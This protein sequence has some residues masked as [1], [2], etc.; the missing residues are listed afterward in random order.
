MSML[1]SDV[2]RSIIG[3]L[4]RKR[5]LSLR[6]TNKRLYTLCN[7]VQVRIQ[8]QTFVFLFIWKLGLCGHGE[9]YRLVFLE[10]PKEIKVINW[11][12]TETWNEEEFRNRYCIIRVSLYELRKYFEKS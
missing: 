1:C 12:R 6:A 7:D 3:V 5:W 8:K 9:R 2:W 10:I 11:D 4:D